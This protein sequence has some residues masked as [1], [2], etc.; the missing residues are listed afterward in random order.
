MSAINIEFIGLELNRFLHQEPHE[1]FSGF[2]Q[3]FAESG[4]RIRQLI[5]NIRVAD[6]GHRN[7]F[8][9]IHAS[10]HRIGLDFGRDAVGERDKSGRTLVC[11]K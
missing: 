6:A 10:A 8:R 9:E 3:G 11:R 2:L 1:K 5:G 7:I 4:Q